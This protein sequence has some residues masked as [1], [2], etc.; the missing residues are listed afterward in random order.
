MSSKWNPVVRKRTVKS[1]EF[2]AVLRLL[3]VL[4]QNLKDDAEKSVWFKQYTL[5]WDL[6]HD[7][8]MFAEQRT[9][10]LKQYHA[11]EQAYILLFDSFREELGDV[12]ASYITPVLNYAER[13]G[14]TL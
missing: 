2:Y 13:Y 6:E 7:E 12:D 5:H 9:D 11:E 10:G 14:V 4:Q 8:V 1:E 3:E